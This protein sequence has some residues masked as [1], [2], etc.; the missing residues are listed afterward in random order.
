[1]KAYQ[2]ET[3]IP[4]SAEDGVWI[5][6]PFGWVIDAT[7]YPGP[8]R[9]TLYQRGLTL[10]DAMKRNEFMYVAFWKKKMHPDVDTLD[11]LL[12]FQKGYM[13]ESSPD[14]EITSRPGPTPQREGCTTLIR[15][16]KK[17]DTSI[18]EITGFVDFGDFVFLCV[19]FTPE[20]LERK[21]QL[22]LDFILRD[23][24]RMH[25]VQKHE[26]PPGPAL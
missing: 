4:Y 22:K 12:E 25:I 11:K 6:A 17:T 14:A 10:E 21:N 24:F 16:F 20:R 19:L 7:Q 2:G 13:L 18:V 26:A 3:A 8:A 1:L 23:A 15:R 9:A 5:A